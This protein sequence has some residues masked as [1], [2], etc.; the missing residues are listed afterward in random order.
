MKEFLGWGGYTR[1][2]EG[3]LSWQHILFVTSLMAVMTALAIF[4]GKR[5]RFADEKKKNR[6]LIWTAIAMDGIELVK[7]VVFCFRAQNPYEWIYSLPLFLCSIQLITIPLAAF[8]K[9]IV[10]QA[11]LDF[12]LIF[13][14]LGAAAGTYGAAQLYGVFPVLSVD[15]VVSGITHAISGFATLYIAF[16]GL[17]SLKKKN[18]P[19][20]FAILFFFCIAAY[21]TNQFIDFNYMFLTHGAGTPY[22]VLYNLVGGD[23]VL[24]PLGVV[25]LFL[26]YISVFYLIRHFVLKRR[27]RK[28]SATESIAK[29]E[30]PEQ[31]T[32]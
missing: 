28:L 13:G 8:S 21:I 5:N 17:T 15:T 10:K 26:L 7:I 30:A 20:T 4:L 11:A 19:I 9:G 3:F 32:V 23:P 16:S 31:A 2:V 24:Y 6:V 12:I 25:A 27:A 1:P 29:E 14:L 18:V 22:D